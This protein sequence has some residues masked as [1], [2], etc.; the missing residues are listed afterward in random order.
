MTPFSI[1]FEGESWI[2][3]DGPWRKV[4]L[5]L[6]EFRDGDCADLTHWSAKDYEHQWL[7][8]LKAVLNQREKGALIVCLHDPSYGARWMAWT[9]WRQAEHVVF[10]N[11]ILFMLEDCP[12]VDPSRIW[13]HVADYQSHTD[14]GQRISE[15]VVPL[16][17]IRHFIDEAIV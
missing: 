9:M 10:Q 2:D 14:E 15:W 1:N 16:S 7:S 17:A 5:T 13:E 11:Q 3:E 8:E 4:S 12:D 6:G